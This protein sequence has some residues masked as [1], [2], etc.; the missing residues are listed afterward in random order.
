MNKTSAPAFSIARRHTLSM[1]ENTPGP[2]EYTPSKAK[3]HLNATFSKSPRL[4]N[5]YQLSPG[6][7][8]YD[9]SPPKPRPVSFGTKHNQ[10]KQQDEPGPADYSNLAFLNQ[11]RA[12]SPG[13][14]ISGPNK[15]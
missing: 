11:T 5:A 13:Y 3:A 6:P 15:S 7:G 9:P 2:G 1:L 14:S 10:G 12:R 4:K 8:A